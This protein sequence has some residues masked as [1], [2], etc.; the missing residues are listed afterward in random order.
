[1]Y[2]VRIFQLERLKYILKKSVNVPG[3][4]GRN[5]WNIT[6]GGNGEILIAAYDSGLQ[7]IYPD[8]KQ[9][10][11]QLLGM[12]DGLPIQRVV[13]VQS[14]DGEY[15]MTT[16]KGLVHY[17]PK[18]NRIT[19]YDKRDGIPNHDLLNYWSESLDISETGEVMFGI[20]NQFCYLS[21]Q[22]NTQKL[23]EHDIIFTQI[24]VQGEEKKFDL[25][26]PFLD[27][28]KLKSNENFFTVHFSDNSFN[29]PTDL[30]FKH[31]LFGFDT[32]W[33]ESST[34]GKATYTRVPGGKYTFEVSHA[35]LATH[36]VARLNI[37]I[38]TPFYRRNWFYALLALFLIALISLVYY[39]RLAQYKSKERLK[40]DFTRKLAEVEMSALRAQMN[41]HFLFNSLNSINK[42]ILTNEPRVASQYLTKFSRLI[43]LILN[44]SKQKEISLEDELDALYL[45]IEMEQLRSNQKF[46][47]EKKIQTTSPIS[48]IF[49]PPMLIQ[50]YIENAIWHGLMPLKDNG[51][52]LL[53]I[54]QKDNML[55]CIID[56]NG[57]G[58]EKAMEIKHKSGLRKQ[59]MGMQITSDRLTLAEALHKI[60]TELNILDKIS[61][62]GNAEGTRITLKIPFN[63][64]KNH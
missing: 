22:N 24:D 9:D 21:N 52:L 11:F 49:I 59:S 20:P 63:V 44:N 13:R 48:Q 62:D 40:S 32:D 8:E 39:Y 38:H 43:R 45:Y 41:P 16:R 35:E 50:P 19:T 60:K 33:V 17:N 27:H 2:S 29:R 3:T 61:G 10:S 26:I 54:A 14:F 36:S 18:N 64:R 23:N 55:V 57:I 1:M 53:E 6:P 7:I 56:D 42:Y 30:N 12:Q 37:L 5:F 58:R 34:P 28:I 47:F 46:T 4:E 25:N 51:H 31:R 15:W